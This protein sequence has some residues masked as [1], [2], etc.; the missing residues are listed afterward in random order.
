[1]AHSGHVSS[2]KSKLTR[3]AFPGPPLRDTRPQ[4]DP[5]PHFLPPITQSS[6]HMFYTAET[7]I[8]FTRS[9]IFQFAFSKNRGVDIHIPPVFALQRYTYGALCRF[10]DK[11]RAMCYPFPPHYIAWCWL[12][13]TSYTL[14]MGEKLEK[15]ILHGGLGGPNNEKRK[16]KILIKSESKATTS[17]LRNICRSVLRS[18]K[19]CIPS[20]VCVF[21]TCLTSIWFKGG[22]PILRSLPLYTLFERFVP[23]RFRVAVLISI[24]ASSSVLIATIVHRFMVRQLLKYTTWQLDPRHFSVHCL[25]GPFAPYNAAGTGERRAEFFY[26]HPLSANVDFP[27]FWDGNTIRETNLPSTGVVTSSVPFRSRVWLALLRRFVHTTIPC[28]EVYERCLPSQPLPSLEETINDYLTA[29]QAL[30]VPFST[31]S[32]QKISPLRVENAAKWKKE[33]EEQCKD[34]EWHEE[35]DNTPSTTPRGSF[36]SGGAQSHGISTPFRN[37]PSDKNPLIHRC[38]VDIHPLGLSVKVMRSEWCQLCRLSANFLS[39][40]GPLLQKYLDSRWH[41]EWNIFKWPYS[42][43]SSSRVEANF[44]AEW[45][46]K[47]VYLGSRNP[48]PF[49]SNYTVALHKNFTPTRIPTSRA[50]V[51]VYL[52]GQMQQQ[53]K[54]RSLPPVFSGPSG[55]V[56]VS[57]QQLFQAFY[58]TRLPGRAVDELQHFKESQHFDSPSRSKLWG[59]SADGYVCFPSARYIVVIYKGAMYQLFLEY[60]L[61]VE[62]ELLFDRS[63]PVSVSTNDDSGEQP[64]EAIKDERRSSSSDSYRSSIFSHSAV[65]AKNARLVRG[66]KM[67][68][69]TPRM[70]EHCLEWI[71]NDVDL[72]EKQWEESLMTSG[73]AKSV[74]DHNSLDVNKS[75]GQRQSHKTKEE[76][77]DDKNPPLFLPSGAKVVKSGEGKETIASS[78]FTHPES[79]FASFLLPSNDPLA[80]EKEREYERAERLIPSL[81]YAPRAVWADAR[82]HYFVQDPFNCFPLQVVEQ[83]MFMLSLEGITPDLGSEPS[84]EKCVKQYRESAKRQV[85]PR[86]APQVLA[87]TVPCRKNA[88]DVARLSQEWKQENDLAATVVKLPDPLSTAETLLSP[89]EGSPIEPS[90]QLK[91][92]SEPAAFAPLHLQNEMARLTSPDPTEGESSRDSCLF[93]S[94]PR[95][96]AGTERPSASEA[97][98]MPGGNGYLFPENYQDSFLANQ[99]RSQQGASRFPHLWADKSFHLLMDHQGFAGFHVESSWGDPAVFQWI[100]DY[101][102]FMELQKKPSSTTGASKLSETSSPSYYYYDEKG[103]AAMLADEK[104]FFSTPLAEET[105]SQHSRSWIFESKVFPKATPLTSWGGKK[106]QNKQKSMTSDEEGDPQLTRAPLLLTPCRLTFRMYQSLLSAIENAHS[107]AEGSGFLT[108]LGYSPVVAGKGEV[109]RRKD[110]FNSPLEVCTVNIRGLGRKSIEEALSLPFLDGS[111]E[112]DDNGRV[113][114][115]HPPFGIEAGAFILVAIQLAYFESVGFLS[116]VYETIPVLYFRQ[117]RSESIRC[118]SAESLACMAALAQYADASPSNRPAMRSPRELLTYISEACRAHTRKRQLARVGRGTEHHLFGLSLMCKKLHIPSE[119][120][121]RVVRRMRWRVHIREHIPAMSTINVGDYSMTKSE[122]EGQEGDGLGASQM[123]STQCCRSLLPMPSRAG[124]VMHPPFTLDGYGVGFTFHSGFSE[125]VESKAIES[126]DISVSCYR[127]SGVLETVKECSAS[128]FAHRVEKWLLIMRRILIEAKQE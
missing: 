101:V 88:Q 76:N 17:S 66:K 4:H 83:A 81:T 2:H 70:L 27:L 90:D 56:P 120:L 105:P 121:N 52:L 23:A 117:S 80:G 46:K 89:K 8:D 68:P 128:L 61:D 55:R 19:S 124:A 67:A 26:W 18:I 123:F 37:S 30:Y 65:R 112:N 53:I 25:Q 86:H 6:M 49:M 72:K 41:S 44:I 32:L 13:L 24:S 39:H 126:V 40:E 35:D 31:E 93:T 20:Q 122:E 15:Q 96:E 29:S 108:S 62:E 43:A 103:R 78:Q 34:C 82:E 75:Y 114:T 50:A 115:T 106:A 59:H 111:S 60:P 51:L 127:S 84:S 110:D 48:L 63:A 54:D 28:T 73:V 94:V 5:S 16:R 10:Y 33:I 109:H 91:D 58:T 113:H 12:V 74:S 14:W 21:L 116:Q 3:F 69:C 9:H 85:F 57:M 98:P 71:V 42:A 107:I 45:W 99:G 64:T 104:D 119:F 125:S 118:L 87:S 77:Q 47:S 38:S 22:L 100:V 79:P 7:P 1:M 11:V 97:A 92:S 36:F 95:E 102:T